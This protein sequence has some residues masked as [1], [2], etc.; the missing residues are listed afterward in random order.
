MSYFLLLYGENTN[1]LEKP[2]QKYEFGIWLLREIM[3]QTPIAKTV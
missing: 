2:G 3:V 1:M